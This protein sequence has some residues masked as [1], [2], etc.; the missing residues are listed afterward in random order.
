VRSE[1]STNGDQTT[2]DGDQRNNDMQ[3]SEFCNRHSEYHDTPHYGG[4]A[5]MAA[6][7]AAMI[8]GAVSRV[9]GA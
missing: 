5:I 2:A 3:E 9:P 8:F 6:E 7:S 1:H 4:A